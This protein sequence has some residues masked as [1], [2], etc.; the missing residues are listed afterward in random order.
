MTAWRA[1]RRLL[2]SRPV[3]VAPPAAMTAGARARMYPGSHDCRPAAGVG[4]GA[5]AAAAAAGDSG[6]D[7]RLR[8]VARDRRA[9]TAGVRVCL[10]GAHWREETGTAVPESAQAV[11][12]A[13]ERGRRIRFVAVTRSGGAANTIEYD[14]Y[15][16]DPAG[17]LRYLREEFRSVAQDLI[18]VRERGWTAAGQLNGQERHYFWLAS[19][20]PRPAPPG[21]GRQP[22]APVYAHTSELPFARFLPKT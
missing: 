14:D 9:R 1:G 21:A 5:A 8:S 19:G 4:L 12:A 15:C 20:K 18:A 22:A 17:R 11:A 7:A 6:G 13:W 16:F 10:N 3:R 2:H